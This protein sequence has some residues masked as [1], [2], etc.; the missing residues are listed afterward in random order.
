MLYLLLLRVNFFP[1][2][3]II[4]QQTKCLFQ[5]YRHTT[6]FEYK[7]KEKKKGGMTKMAKNIHDLAKEAFDNGNYQLAM[8]LFQRAL[9][10]GYMDYSTLQVNHDSDNLNTI[11]LIDS[12]FGYGDALARCGHIKESVCVYAFICDRLGYTVSVDKLRHL[13]YG[14]I[15]SILPASASYPSQ[16]QHSPLTGSSA[17]TASVPNAPV[18]IAPTTPPASDKY[19]IMNDTISAVMYKQHYLNGNKMTVYN[20]AF[21]VNVTDD[22]LVTSKMN[23][24][25]IDFINSTS[26]SNNNNN[27][28]NNENNENNNT[29]NDSN[30][31]NNLMRKSSNNIC[32]SDRTVL[33]DKCISKDII[34]CD[35]LQCPLC[36]DILMWPVTMN[37]GHS[38][39]RQ[40]VYGQTQCFVCGKRFIQYGYGLKQD[41]SISRLIEK[42]WQPLIHAQFLN[43]EAEVYLR[44]NAFDEA[45]KSCNS[46]LQKRKF[47]FFNFSSLF[48]PFQK[49]S[50]T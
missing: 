39:C 33:L 34:E 40:C 1:F 15:E 38:Y 35:P 25:N 32:N 11:L 10:S 2:S 13:T 50:I 49:L 31:N 12:Y 30:N 21:D 14:L 4:K 43:A 45:L 23:N 28:N 22:D 18:I 3:R 16:H 41:V 17:S 20:P 44:Q 8:D 36:D 46:S 48:M 42:W 47:F 26:N 37:C 24:K 29:N 9:Q 5:T 27:T 19:S 6:V 7:K